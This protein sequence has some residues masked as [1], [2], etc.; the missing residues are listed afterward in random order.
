MKA[1]HDSK[2]QNYDRACVANQAEHL[3][4][5]LPIEKQYFGRVLL[6]TLQALENKALTL[7]KSKK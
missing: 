3:R 5:L 1:Q 6:T 4:R 7:K 2:N